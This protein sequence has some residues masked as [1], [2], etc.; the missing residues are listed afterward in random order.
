MFGSSGSTAS[1]ATTPSFSF[2]SRCCPA[3]FSRAFRLSLVTKNGPL[4]VDLLEPC[5]VAVS[6]VVCADAVRF[7]AEPLPRRLDVG[8]LPVAHDDEARQVA[9]A[10]KLRV[11]LDRPLVRAVARPVVRFQGYRHGRAVDGEERVPEAEAVPGGEL[12]ASGRQF[13]EQFAEHGRVATVHRIRESRPGDRL[14]AR[15]MEP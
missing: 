12:L 3:T 8:H 5:V 10:V 7:D 2:G 13:I 15:M 4:P 1:S 11:Q 6:L 14:H 9:G